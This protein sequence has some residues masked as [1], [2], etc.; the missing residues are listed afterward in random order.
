MA[1][2]RKMADFG[3]GLL[4]TCVLIVLVAWLVKCAEGLA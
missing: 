2:G 4:V 1:S 3:S